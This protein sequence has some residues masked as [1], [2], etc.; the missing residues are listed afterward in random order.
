VTTSLKARALEIAK[1]QI[2]VQERGGR[3]TGPE[4]DAYLLAV[5]KGP[6]FSWCAAFIVW[7]YAK[8]AREL[9]YPG[10][11]IRRTGKVTRLWRTSSGR[12]GGRAPS[13]GAIFCHASDPDDPESPG[14]CGLVVAIHNDGTFTSIEG[15][16]NREGSRDGDSVWQ[17]RRPLTYA[18]L[19]F[20]DV[21]RDVS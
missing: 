4:V 18:N 11:P 9:S 5:G 3:N 2:G 10:L 8:A 15:N 20:L 16:T 19:G 14:H 17:H 13:V 7:C 1:T 6:G 12:Y 21:A